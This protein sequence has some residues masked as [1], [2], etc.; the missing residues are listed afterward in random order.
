MKTLSRTT[1]VNHRHRASR[2]RDGE[3]A[4]PVGRG[5]SRLRTVR[6]RIVVILA[7]PTALLVAISVYG[8]LA[9]ARQAQDASGTSATVDLVLADQ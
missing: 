4:E 8:V 2:R 6:G 7:L 5:L 9:Q 1:N 3:F